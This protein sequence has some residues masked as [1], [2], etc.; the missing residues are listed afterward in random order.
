MDG[1]IRGL[2]EAGLLLGKSWQGGL[3]SGLFGEGI[4]ALGLD[5]DFR[6]VAGDEGGPEG[7]GCDVADDL[8]AG[9]F[10]DFLVGVERDGE[11]Q[12]VVLAA[13][14]GGGDEVHVQFLGHQGCLVVDG[15]LLY[16]SDAADE[17]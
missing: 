2:S 11:E 10:L 17:L 6:A 3:V 16:T 12:L 1:V 8:D 13:V 15:C 4:P 9:D 7:G 14:H 5:G